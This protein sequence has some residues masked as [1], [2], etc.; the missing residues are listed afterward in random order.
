MREGSESESVRKERLGER[1][2]GV[3]VRVSEKK[4][5]GGD[6]EW[7]EREIETETDRQS[8]R[9][10]EIV[11]EQNVSERDKRGRQTVRERKRE[12]VCEGV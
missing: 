4:R 8:Q 10:C 1:E 2:S 12:R 6:R 11:K 7:K 5:P 9:V 3:R